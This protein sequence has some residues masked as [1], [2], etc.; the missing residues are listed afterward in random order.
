[1]QFRDTGWGKY[2]QTEDDQP[3]RVQVDYNRCTG[4]GVC[5]SLAPDVFSIE[6]DGQMHISEGHANEAPRAS[7]ADAVASCP[8]RALTISD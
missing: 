8:T 7:L 3:M 5:E 1:M 6:D 4:L 2:R